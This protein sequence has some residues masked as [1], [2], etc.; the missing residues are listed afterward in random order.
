MPEDP[1]RDPRFIEVLLDF[2]MGR[3]EKRL[4]ASR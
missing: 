4:A 3:V 1:I 2:R